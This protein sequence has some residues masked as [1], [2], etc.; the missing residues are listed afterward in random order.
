MNMPDILKTS[1]SLILSGMLITS[2]NAH[3]KSDNPNK[4]GRWA[5]GGSTDPTA[6]VVDNGDK[7]LLLSDASIVRAGRGNPIS[8]P[9]PTDS[10][11]EED[12][13]LHPGNWTLYGLM[14]IGTESS[15]KTIFMREVNGKI[16]AVQGTLLLRP[17]ELE[18]GLGQVGLNYETFTD[19]GMYSIAVKGAEATGGEEILFP[20]AFL[21]DG[22]R[23]F[24]D[25]TFTAFTANEKSSDQLALAINEDGFTG[26]SGEVV[27]RELYNVK[28]IIQTGG[29]IKK[30]VIKVIYKDGLKPIDFLTSGK[31]MFDVGFN[32]GNLSGIGTFVAG[33]PTTAGDLAALQA[34]DVV[35]RYTGNTFQ[36]NYT[37]DA[38]IYFQSATFNANFKGG[39]YGDF[40]VGGSVNGAGFNST[41]F[42]RMSG[43]IYNASVNGTLFGPAA[44]AMAGQVKMDVKGKYSNGTYVDIF[45]ATKNEIKSPVEIPVII[46]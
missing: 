41:K 34:G 7:L 1:I 35:G 15:G 29:I 42:K 44:E 12:T 25:T 5:K 43:D 2:I 23:I 6:I 38:S 37:I 26:A 45:A 31:L 40:V 10:T 3:A 9:D 14:T 24:A 8:V 22:E 28:D 27:G 19:T 46:K 30:E 11:P 20:I 13:L 33:Q 32:D 36:T 17:P 21:A 18:G 16:A 39:N 4:W